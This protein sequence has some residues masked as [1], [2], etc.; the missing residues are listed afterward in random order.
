MARKY[1]GKTSSGKPAGFDREKAVAELD[2]MSEEEF[3]RMAASSGAYDVIEFIPAGEKQYESA[4]DPG[5]IE[6]IR[7]L[8]HPGYYHPR[9]KESWPIFDILLDKDGKLAKK[10]PTP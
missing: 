10:Q 8:D 5:F 3:R 4:E 2:N 1:L 7:S 6:A 9:D